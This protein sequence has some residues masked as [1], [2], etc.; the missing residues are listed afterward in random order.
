MAKSASEGLSQISVA[1]HKLL[2]VSVK[3]REE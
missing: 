2:S 1:L 3:L